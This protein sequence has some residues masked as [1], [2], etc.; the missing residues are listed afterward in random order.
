[1]S[2]LFSDDIAGGAEAV[3]ALAYRCHRLLTLLA[4][5]ESKKKKRGRGHNYVSFATVQHRPAL[6]AKIAPTLAVAKRLRKRDI[7]VLSGD[8]VIQ[9]DRNFRNNFNFQRKNP[10]FYLIEQHISFLQK[11]N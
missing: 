5:M 8:E 11:F 9:R 3:A 1:M 7:I 2:C 4:R 6:C 10:Y